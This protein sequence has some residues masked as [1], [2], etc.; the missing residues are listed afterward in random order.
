MSDGLE[1]VHLRGLPE[2]HSVVT[3]AHNLVACS[4]QELGQP[5]NTAHKETG[6]DIEENNSR[7]AVG[8]LPVSKKRGLEQRNSENY[9]LFCTQSSVQLTGLWY[10]LMSHQGEEGTEEGDGAKISNV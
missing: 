10:F 9:K 4:V 1:L 8:I 2:P 6:I 5:A 7:V 3:L